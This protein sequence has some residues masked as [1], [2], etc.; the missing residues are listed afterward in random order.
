MNRLPVVTHLSPAEIARRYRTGPDAAARTRWQVIWLV[1]RPDAPLSA[2][3]AAR[4]VG[5][6]LS[7]GRTRLKRWNAHGPD[8]RADGRKDNGADPVRTTAR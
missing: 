2:G 1:T 3:R 7:W 8:G 4:A 5:L 6:T